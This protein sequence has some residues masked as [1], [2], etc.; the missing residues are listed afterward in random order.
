MLV[1]RSLGSVSLISIDKEKLFKRLKDIAALIKKEN[2]EVLEVRLFGSIAKEENTG[3]SDVDIVVIVSGSSEDIFHRTLKFR[4][5][6]DIEV[7]VDILVY[8]KQEIDNMLKEENY[9]IKN[10][11]RE[12]ILL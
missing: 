3:K 1:K 6:F 11:L 9:F 4:R 2:K 12:G 5:Y 8:T 7:P 10:I